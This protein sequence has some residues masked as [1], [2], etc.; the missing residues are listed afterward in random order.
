M[1]RKPRKNEEGR[2][3][4]VMVQGIGKEYVFPDD[5][6]KGY[7]LTCLKKAKQHCEAKLLAFCV[8]GN[9]AHILT[10]VKDSYELANFFR[11]VNSEYAMYYNRTKNRVGYV[12]RD[13]YRSELIT[14]SRYLINCLVYIQNNPVKAGIVTKAENYIYSSYINYITQ[15][16]IIDFEEAEKYY[17]I[18]PDNMRNIMKESTTEEWLENIDREYEDK[19]QVFAEITKKYGLTKDR[20]KTNDELLK[21]VVKEMQLRSKISLREIAKILEIG[22]ETLRKMLSTPPS[23]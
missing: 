6:C 9:H 18:K 11:R 20:I 19:N 14:D 15:S 5:D 22:R 1:P 21:I 3:Y 23:P 7:Y 2:Y 4:H 17:S 12:F 8:L 13:R 10:A 16:G